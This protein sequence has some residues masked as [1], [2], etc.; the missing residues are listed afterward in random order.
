MAFQ[1]R[2]EDD[3]PFVRIGIS[4]TDSLRILDAQDG[5]KLIH[6]SESNKFRA[7]DCLRYLQ[8]QPMS[9]TQ[10]LRQ[11]A[12]GLAVNAARKLKPFTEIWW[13]M[14]MVV[15]EGTLGAR[16]ERT[17]ANIWNVQSTGTWYESQLPYFPR[18]ENGST[19]LGF[20]ED[21][22]VEITAEHLRDSRVIRFSYPPES[23][24]QSGM[25]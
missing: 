15:Y 5:A 24:T 17:V 4:F 3:V 21:I 11:I 6:R 22:A 18:F 7:D 19:V 8:L 14:V 10:E 16:L 2:W 23:H 25:G 12:Q 20:R 9:T 13:E 1:M